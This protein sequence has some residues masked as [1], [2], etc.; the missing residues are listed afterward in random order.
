MRIWFIAIKVGFLAA[1]DLA[2][3]NLDKF[4]WM[5]GIGLFLAIPFVVCFSWMLDSLFGTR[6]APRI[7]QRIAEFAPLVFHSFYVV[8]N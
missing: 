8:P 4:L 3:H 2:Q 5:K 6:S 7:C 1:K